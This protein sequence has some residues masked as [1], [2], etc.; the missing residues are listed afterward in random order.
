MQYTFDEKFSLL[1]RHFL[2]YS[3]FLLFSIYIYT[4]YLLLFIYVLLSEYYYNWPS[5]G[6][7]PGARVLRAQHSTTE[8][9]DLTWNKAEE[10]SWSMLHA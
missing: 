7:N 2:G 1:D 3:I 10:A 8:P 9:P 6:P 5:E 4:Y